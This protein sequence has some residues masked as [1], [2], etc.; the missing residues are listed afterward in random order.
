[1]DDILN[2]DSTFR[3]LLLGRLKADCDYYLGYG[4]RSKNRLWAGDENLQIETMIKLY[5]SFQSDKKPEWLTMNEILNY[6]K[7]M[8]MPNQKIDEK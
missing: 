5:N 1:M 4:N 7:E 3:Y 6:Q 8:M 2:R